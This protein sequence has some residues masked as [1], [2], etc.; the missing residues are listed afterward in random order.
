MLST[1]AMIR[2]GYVYGNLMVNVQ[3]KNQKLVDRASRII[4][5]AANIEYSPAAELLK[6]TGSVKTSIVMAKLKLS[7]EEAEERLRSANGRVRI[8]LES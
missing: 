2:L 8:A 6:Q 7:R 3:P 4:A 1:A 5:Q